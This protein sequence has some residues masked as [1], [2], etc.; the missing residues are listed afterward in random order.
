MCCGVVCVSSSFSAVR[1][2]CRLIGACCLDVV[3][4]VRV[5]CSVLAVG[6]CLPFI[7]CCWLSFAVCCCLVCVRYRLLLCVDCRLLAAVLVGY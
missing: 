7:G 1:C 5:V 4:L 2:W 3:H 6:C